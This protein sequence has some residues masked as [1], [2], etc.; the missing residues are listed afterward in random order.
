M[1]RYRG[2]H[3]AVWLANAQGV[4]SR[5]VKPGHPRVRRGMGAT[6]VAALAMAAL[7]A[8]QAPGVQA[9]QAAADD[10]ARAG[11]SQ[12]DG[13]PG[14]GSYHTELPPLDSPT[15]AASATPQHAREGAGASGIPATVLAAY[16]RAESSIG[17]S[18]PG[19]RLPWQL[20]AAIGKVESGQA[21]G[22]AVDAHGTTLKPILGP[23]LNGDGFADITD[24][25]EGVFDGD[26]VH[27]RAVG[28]M[29]FIPGTWNK[30]GADG[31]GDGR[32][33]PNNVFDAAL[34]AGHYLCAGTRD[35]AVKADLDRAIL[36]YNNSRD[37]LRTVLSWL[38]FY[39]KGVHEVPDGTGV[40]PTS[41][42]AGG[43]DDPSSGGSASHHEPSHEPTPTPSDGHSTE[44]SEHPS[45]SP[46]PDPSQTGPTPDPTPS[47]PV[48]ASI[49]R[50]SEAKVTALPDQDFADPVVVRITDGRGVTP[51]E[52]TEVTFTLAGG[53]TGSTFAGGARTVT[54]HTDQDGKAVSPALHAG[55][56]PGSFTV[57]VAVVGHEKLTTAVQ[58]TVRA[59]ADTIALADPNATYT[60]EAGKTFAT[61]VQVVTT[62]EKKAAGGVDLTA[63]LLTAD[64]KPVAQDGTAPCFTDQDGTALDHVTVSTDQEGHLT[65]PQLTA[66]TAPGTYVLRL[67]TPGGGT[68]DV[69]LTVTA[70]AA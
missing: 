66:G 14:D 50:L 29:Q 38:E 8:S 57:Q 45:D 44:P 53:G 4:A 17:K 23:V 1:T 37:Y 61:D 54:V 32:R 22:G 20:L 59:V 27:D 18:D 46:S 15:P 11:A 70:P 7:T 12:A 2:R 63:T 28:P 10:D 30:W 26:T 41:P 19:C 68:L 5:S 58:A 24:T 69:T 48:P 40:L 43:L 60:A 65:L 62:R 36:S 25:D 47:A 51:V 9:P 34:A 35:L 6:A 33:D 42:G 64:G 16:R 49:Q 39:R 56:T 21:R 31:N 55:H 52:G 13:S 3:T 67:T